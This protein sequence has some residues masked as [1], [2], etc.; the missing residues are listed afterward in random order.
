MRF[1]TD[2][3][4]RVVQQRR[5]LFAQLGVA[6]E[7]QEARGGHPKAMSVISSRASFF[8]YQLSP[9]TLRL[10]SGA[11]SRNRSMLP[12]GPRWSH[13][14]RSASAK[15]AARTTNAN[16]S[17]LISTSVHSRFTVRVSLTCLPFPQS[18]THSHQ[19]ASSESL[20][21]SV[22]APALSPCKRK[23]RL[24][25]WGSGG[26]DVPNHNLSRHVCLAQEARPMRGSDGSE[27]DANLIGLLL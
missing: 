8:G 4:V 1:N 18:P 5:Q 10:N 24:Q 9:E 2:Q 25:G 26:M 6:A 3:I 16:A 7:R 21:P 17:Y 11:I 22:S 20:S 19:A 27:T 15:V 12:S 23:R 13:P 14:T